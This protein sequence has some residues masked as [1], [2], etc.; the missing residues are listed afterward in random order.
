MDVVEA[1]RKRNSTRAFRPDPVPDDVLRAILDAARE[2]PSWSNTQPYLIAMASG[3]KCAALRHDM[4]DAFD[5]KVPDGDYPLLV[6]Y[7]TPL[8]ERR[9]ATGFGLYDKLG[10]AREDKPA[11]AMQF[12]KNF[13]FFDAPAVLFL[14]AHDALGV[15]SVLDAGI[16]LGAILLA[17]TNVGVQTC[18]QAA[19]ASFPDVVRKHFDVPERYKLLCGVAL[20]YAADDVVN[21][22]RPARLSVEQMTIPPRS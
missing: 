9:H 15:Y 7:P 8:R 6:E 13:A 11:R 12:R 5:T 14:F 4:L 19:L 10:I 1:L 21:S 16:Y 22:F 3:P 18:S 20:G 17:A 2:A